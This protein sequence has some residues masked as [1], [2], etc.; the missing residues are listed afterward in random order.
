DDTEDPDPAGDCDEDN[1]CD[2][3][4]D[5][6]LGV[7]CVE[8]A[9]VESINLL[10][11]CDDND[12]CTQ[13]DSCGED[14][15]CYG[16][17]AGI[18][19]VTCLYQDLECGDSFI[20]DM[21]DGGTPIMN[22]YSGAGCEAMDTGYEGWE[23]TLLLGANFSAQGSITVELIEDD[24][25][26]EYVDVVELDYDAGLCWPGACVSSG[27]MSPD[28]RVEMDIELV[29][30][31]K[32]VLVFDGRASYS[33]DVWITAQCEGKYP[34]AFCMDGTDDD[35]DGSID[36]CDSD[37]VGHPSCDGECSCTDGVDNDGDNQTDCDDSD[38]S[39]DLAC[40]P[41]TIC[42]DGEDNDGDGNADCDDPDCAGQGDC[43]A[44]A[45]CPDATPLLCGSE[46]FGESLSGGSTYFADKPI[47]GCAGLAN[48]TSTYSD[49]P[50]RIYQVT[51]DEGCVVD[52]VY[53]QNS[54]GFFDMYGLA[55]GCDG[56]SCVDA[57][58]WYAD[59]PIT[60]DAPS[61]W[62]GVFLSNGSTASLVDDTYDISVLC[63]CE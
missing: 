49:F 23:R 4:E 55:P 31:E 19:P 34:E 26:S 3:P 46:L 22:G 25:G 60:L 20:L 44:G 59:I 41:E 17:S 63:K 28:G 47:A 33:D 58:F 16:N 37:C 54:S 1:P 51:A 39:D 6:C 30:D 38:C 36:C 11:A 32:N 56:D 42:D 18:C 43:A 2:E 40:Q 15:T 7:E 62:V 27:L 50:H 8:G 52:M 24:A 10:D 57:N 53:L 35:G 29:K 9:C 45:M 13:Q 14:G 21:K 12:V 61:G 5:Q 48:T